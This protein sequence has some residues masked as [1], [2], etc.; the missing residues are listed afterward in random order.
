M[1]GACVLA[2]LRGLAV[3]T[4]ERLLSRLQVLAGS[5]RKRELSVYDWCTGA[6][7]SAEARSAHTMSPTSPPTVH[8]ARL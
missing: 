8:M 2:R 6:Y 5:D 7:H 3:E 1:A 4:I